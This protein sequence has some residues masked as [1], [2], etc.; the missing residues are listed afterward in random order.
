MKIL[1]DR[2]YMRAAGR[3]NAQLLDELRT[4]INPGVKLS[5]LDDF[6]YQYTCDHG[7]VPAPLNYPGVHGVPFPKS[8]CT[9]VNDVICHGIPGDYVLNDG[10]IINVDITSIVNGYHGDQ[11]ET[12]L[13]GNV[14]DQARAVTQCAFNSMWSAIESLQPGCKVD[15]IGRAIECETH[16]W[17][18][19]I[20]REY[21]GHGIDQTFHTDPFIPHV[22]GHPFGEAILTP[23]TC[24]TIEP[25]INTG[26]AETIL[27]P[28]DKWT[29]RTADGGLSAQFEHTILMTESGPEVLTLT[30]NGPKPG[31]QF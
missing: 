19:S 26:S 7:H 10:D 31:H 24:F 13:I 20:V 3:F 22:A 23:G 2:E 25:M 17:G 12:F 5:D 4:K 21:Y 18:F 16:Q 29:V 8:C 1:N 6:V 14:S 15:I 9:S 27:D 11:S 30:S 28:N